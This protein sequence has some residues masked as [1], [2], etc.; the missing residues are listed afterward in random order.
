MQHSCSN[1]RH[2]NITSDAPAVPQ[3]FCNLTEYFLLHSIVGTDIEHING[4]E[5]IQRKIQHCCDQTAAEI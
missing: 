4:T 2:R 5:G 3:C 1:N